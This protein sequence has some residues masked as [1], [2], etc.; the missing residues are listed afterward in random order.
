MPPLDRD[1]TARKNAIDFLDD[2]LLGARETDISDG[3]KAQIAMFLIESLVPIAEEEEDI[4][5]TALLG[6]ETSA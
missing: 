1:T 2:I 5:L 4:T 6:K 3:D